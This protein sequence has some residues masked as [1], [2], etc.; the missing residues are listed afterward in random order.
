M[1]EFL[2]NELT[3]G[4]SP[5]PNEASGKPAYRPP[6]GI[7][8]RDPAS[9]RSTIAAALLHA[10]IVALI[11]LPPLLTARQVLDVRNSAAGGPG[12]AGGGGGGTLGDG[13]LRDVRERLRFFVLPRAVP[14]QPAPVPTPPVEAKKEEPKPLPPPAPAADSAQATKPDSATGNGTSGGTGRDGTAGTGSGS[15]GGVGSGLGPGRGSGIGP[16][17]GGGEGDIYPP[18]VVSLPVLPLPI[19]GK[20][21]PYH[22]VAYFDVDTLGNAKLISFTPSKD[23]GYNKRVREMLLEIRFRPAVRANG[24]AV[25]D[26]AVV[27]A[28]AM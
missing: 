13:G 9:A 5:K 15:G 24:V 20:V 26:T 8:T 3:G 28:D 2:R 16:G 12:P 6:V 10:L 23:G 27:T 11:L 25:R 1:T 7:P 4:L 19:P 18:S 17:T 21:R 22:M 14:A